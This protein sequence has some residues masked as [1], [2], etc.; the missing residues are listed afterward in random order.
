MDGFEEVARRIRQLETAKWTPIIFL[1]ARTS[2]AD[3]EK[4]IA[5][6]GTDYLPDQAGVE[7]VLAAKVRPCSAS[8]RCAYSLLVLTRKLD[9]ANQELTG[10]PPLTGSHRHRQPPP[11]RRDPAPRMAAEPSSGRPLALLL[12]DVDLFKQFNG[13]GH[14]VG[15]EC[16]PEG[17]GAAA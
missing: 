12:A 3:L 13:Y 2:D 7:T 4:G 1:T 10:C 14:R 11:V 17:R 15:D 9:E 5:V 16:L 8:P 6:G